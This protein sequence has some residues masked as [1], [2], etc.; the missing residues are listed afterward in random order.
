MK[1]LRWLG[2]FT[3]LSAV[4]FVSY[5]ISHAATAQ[6]VAAAGVTSDDTSMLDLLRPVYEALTS[7]QYALTTALGLIAAVALAKRYLGTTVPWLHSDAGGSLLVLVGSGAAAAATGLVAPGT[8]VTL[9]LIKNALMAGVLAAGGYAMIKNLIVLP[10]LPYLP[11]WLRTALTPLLWVFD[12]SSKPAQVVLA[13]SITAG[14]EAVAAKPA[15]G[16]IG[17]VSDVREIK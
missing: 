3:A 4:G 7:G 17:I 15:Q 5:G 9:A 1:I 8:H 13:Q 10:L 11:A 2:V 12:G 6:L 16:V 14:V